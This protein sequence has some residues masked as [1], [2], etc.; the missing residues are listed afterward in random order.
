ML[1]VRLE[2]GVSR[3]NFPRLDISSRHI[4]QFLAWSE[5]RGDAELQ[6]SRYNIRLLEDVLQR[7]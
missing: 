7:R 5:R 1:S 4:G 3:D 6:Q 2:I